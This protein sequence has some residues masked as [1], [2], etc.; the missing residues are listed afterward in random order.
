[1]TAET[2]VGL[3]MRRLVVVGLH[4]S[5]FAADEPDGQRREARL[6]HELVSRP[7]ESLT[8]SYAALDEDAQPLH[9][10]PFLTEVELLFPDSAL[11]RGAPLLAC[12]DAAEEPLSRREA[13]LA[14][15]VRATEGDPGPLAAIA[16]S[17]SPTIPGA[18]VM[19]DARARGDSFGDFEGV[20]AP[21]DETP[22][23]ELRDRYGPDHVWSAS[24]LELYGDLP[25]QVLRPPRAPPRTE[26]GELVPRRSITA[27]AA[28]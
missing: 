13:R 26:A 28:V 3:T 16:R 21:N 8:L 6:F 24:Q 27:A 14:A 2:A 18:L 20:V 11:R 19:I 23:G 5:A 15:V 10:S 9:P 4:E 7:S 1:M 25:V 17:S 12:F 22:G